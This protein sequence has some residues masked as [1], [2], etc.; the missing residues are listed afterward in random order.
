M[1]RPA[2]FLDR[3]GTLIEE[4]GYLDRLDLLELY[5]WTVDAIRL[6]NRAGV[7]TVIV[8]NQ[9]AIGRG[10]IDEPFLRR[11]HDAID[12]R[13]AAGRAR[14][15]AYYFCPHHP[16]AE[17]E[18]YREV[19]SC[20]KP[21]PGLIERACRDLQIDPA[22]SV[23]VGDRWL[24]VACGRAAG[25]RAVLV[26]TGHGGHEVEHTPAGASADAILN[27]LMEAVGWILRSSCR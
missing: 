2:V 14:M 8:T 21:K 10:I 19:C 24:D 11:V 1:M 16:D 5:P 12:A 20:R 17:L 23:M 9:S 25:T 3:D 26:R 6:L 15:D 22:R 7:A 13:L 4:R 18:A 27:N